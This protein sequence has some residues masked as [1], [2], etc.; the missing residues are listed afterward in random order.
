MIKSSG[1]HSTSPKTLF[2]WSYLLETHAGLKIELICVQTA[3]WD[4]F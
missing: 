3:S 4:T 2:P 1:S